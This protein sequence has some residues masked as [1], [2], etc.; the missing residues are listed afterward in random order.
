MP[1]DQKLVV[2]EMRPDNV[3]AVELSYALTQDL[4]ALQVVGTATLFSKGGAAPQGGKPGMV[5]RNRFEYWSA[6]L[7][8]PPVKSQT[9]IDAQVA[10][11]E[12]KYAGSAKDPAQDAKRKSEIAEAR[13]G[14]SARANAEYMVQQWLVN[15]GV[16][17]QEA[18]RSG[19]S[20]VVNLLASDL[21]DPTNVDV[22]AKLPSESIVSEM[23]GRVVARSNIGAYIGSLASRP[24]G[25][26]VPLANATAYRPVQKAPVQQSAAR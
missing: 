24:T 3:L 6:P 16:R 22:K 1:P 14:N 10:A 13:N 4:R 23:K 20:A 15:D 25:Y 8:A 2:T 17:L 26:I 18:I 21:A 11:I 12:A 7:P 5:Y 19:T 9:E